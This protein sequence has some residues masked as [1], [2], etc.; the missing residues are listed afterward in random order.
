MTKLYLIR[1][2][3]AEGNLYRR[4]HGHYNSLI[5]DNGYQ[6]IRALEARFKDIPIDAAYSSDLF[7]TMTTA[8]AITIPKGLELRTRPDLRE[9]YMGDWEDRTWAGIDRT[10]HETMALFSMGS[11]L[12]RS[13][14]GESLPELRQRSTAAILDI[15]SKHNGQTV[16]VF[17]HGTL[18]RNALAEFQGIDYEGMRKMKHS[19]NTAVALL[20]I[21]NGKV[22]VVFSDDNSHLSQEIST[23][24]RQHWWKDD[25]KKLDVNLWFQRADLNDPEVRAFYLTCREEAWQSLYGQLDKYNG[26][27]FLADAEDAWKQEPR[28]VMLAMAGR[29]K[30]G[31]LQLDPARFAGDNKGY[32][33]FFY[34]S[35][36]RRGSNLGVQI[37]GKAVSIYRSMGRDTLRLACSEKNTAALGFYHKYGFKT[38]GITAGAYNA[39]YELEKPIGYHNQGELL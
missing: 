27:G 37:L 4:I 6:Q 26:E 32:I 1:H 25:P 2:A 24:A 9:L 16:A 8:K 11:P 28:S 20:E 7:R 39:L 30:A 38:V 5:T 13:P 18:I 23:L 12:F 36:D 31:I 33:S 29:R 21:E 15:A 19:D 10:D 14:N 34:L 3:E 22:T 35:P 17:A